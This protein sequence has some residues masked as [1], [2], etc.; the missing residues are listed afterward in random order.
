MGR[1]GWWEGRATSSAAR[2]GVARPCGLP[3]KRWER[4]GASDDGVREGGG[5]RVGVGQGGKG[6][7][8]GNDVGTRNISSISTSIGAYELVENL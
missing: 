2:E 6:V 8:R 3:P 4:A 1:E 5:R 7:E